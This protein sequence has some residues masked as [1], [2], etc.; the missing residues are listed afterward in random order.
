MK[1]AFLLVLLSWVANTTYA[2]GD[3][4]S[5]Q[6]E[7]RGS[8]KLIRED[9]QVASFQAIDIGPFFSKVI[10]EVGGTQ[11]V[12]NIQLDDNLNSFLHIESVDNVLRLSFKDPA[13]KPFWLSKG[14][15]QITIRTPALNQLR[16]ESNGDVVVNNLT[17]SSFKLING[18]NGNVTLR[19]SVK[20]LNVLSEA[21]GDVR[22]EELVVQDATITTQANATVNVNARQ[23]HA[24]NAGHATVRNVA[25]KGKR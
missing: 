2:Q 4:Y 12:V 19:G 5:S 6:R 25:D 9:R 14:T 15:I 7:L 22:A 20:Q 16:N 1:Q 18:A 10:V 3:K 11:S 21:N 8:G 24:Q 13:N 17:S 23:V